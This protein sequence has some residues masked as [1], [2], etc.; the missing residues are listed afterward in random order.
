MGSRS[1]RAPA[2]TGTAS[3]FLLREDGQAA[4]GQ[5]FN[6]QTAILVKGILLRRLE[7]FLAVPSGIRVKL[8]YAFDQGIGIGCE[9]AGGT[10]L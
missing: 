4:Y 5:G 3:L 1:S 6:S 9:A 10:N 2:F 8:K 7:K